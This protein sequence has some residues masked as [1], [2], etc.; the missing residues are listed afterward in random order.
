MRVEREDGDGRSRH[1]VVHVRDPR[2]TAEFSPDPEAPDKVGSGVLKRLCVPNSWAG[3]YGQY[4]P[5]LKAAQEFFPPI[6]ADRVRAEAGDAAAE[7]LSVS[8]RSVVDRAVGGPGRGA[9]DDE[10]EFGGGVVAPGVA[11]AGADHDG[12][13][14]TDAGLAPVNIMIPE[15]AVT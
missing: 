11:R 1:F 7:I 4:A 13:A 14:D 5:L 8:H 10:A 6:A 2:F 9:G 15:P 12:V 3:N